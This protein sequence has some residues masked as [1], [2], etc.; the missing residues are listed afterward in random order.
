MFIVDFNFAVYGDLNNDRLILKVLIL[1][2]IRIGL[3]NQCVEALG[4]QRRDHHKNDQKNQQNVDQRN[5][6]HFRHRTALTFTYLHSHCESPVGSSLRRTGAIRPRWVG[7]SAASE[8]VR[9]LPF[10]T[11][12]TTNGATKYS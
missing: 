4:S 6:V 9:Q 8:L 10:T 3:R 1:L 5:D 7:A 12:P 2:L 11:T